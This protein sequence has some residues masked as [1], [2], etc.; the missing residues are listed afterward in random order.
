VFDAALVDIDQILPEITPVAKAAGSALTGML[1]GLGAA[2]TD[3]Q[4][5]QFFEFLR[6]NI[7][8]DM[9]QITAT[10]VALIRTFFALTEALHPLSLVMLQ[11]VTDFAEFLSMLSKASP[12]LLDLIVLSIALYKPL[13]AIQALQLL[14]AFTRIPTAVAG[15]LHSRRRPGIA[16]PGDC[17]RAGCRRRA[18]PVRWVVLGSG[19][20]G[21]IF[22]AHKWGCH[23]GRIAERAIAAGATGFGVRATVTP[24]TLG[25]AADK[26]LRLRIHRTP[27]SRAGKIRFGAVRYGRALGI[28]LPLSSGRDESKSPAFSPVSS[29]RVRSH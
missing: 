28:S 20:S 10:L 15:W 22:L 9:Q 11:L 21:L 7:G 14:R 8:P 29:R 18:Q 5:Q 27:G 4:A 6:Q 12:L 13:K 26:Q 16:R 3:T 23:E 17:S 24:A 19:A 1:T 25:T 2:L